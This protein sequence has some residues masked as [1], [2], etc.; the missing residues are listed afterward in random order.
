MTLIGCQTTWITFLSAT[1]WI[2]RKE[3]RREEEKNW[4]HI[5][6][7]KY[8]FMLYSRQQLVI[9]ERATL[10]QFIKFISFNWKSLTLHFL[11]LLILRILENFLMIVSSCWCYCIDATLVVYARKA[12]WKLHFNDS[13]QFQLFFFSIRGIFLFFFKLIWTFFILFFFFLCIALIE[14]NL[15]WKWASLK[16]ALT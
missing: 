2:V 11:F 9:T 8:S 7:R 12:R 6:F 15:N 3:K 10:Q 13:N 5:K 16:L 14:S 4:L 1:S